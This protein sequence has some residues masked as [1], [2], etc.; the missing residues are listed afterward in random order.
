M[1]I[2]DIV[3][4]IDSLKDKIIIAYRI[5]NCSPRIK[6]AIKEWKLEG[7]LPSISVE[8]EESEDKIVEISSYELVNLYEF[9][10]L[11]SLLMLDSLEKAKVKNDKERIK[12]LTGFL[13]YGTHVHKNHLSEEMMNNIKESNPAVW[14]EYQKICNAAK[15]ED[16][17]RRNKFNNIIETEL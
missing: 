11:S 3:E 2:K 14:E 13:I 16:I 4:S 5:Y 7:S 8:L 17:E 15:D 6:E 9:D 12:Q 1:R 10:E